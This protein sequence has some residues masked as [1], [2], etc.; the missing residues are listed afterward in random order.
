MLRTTKA[1]MTTMMRNNKCLHKQ[2]RLR[3]NSISKNRSDEPNSNLS[4][5]NKCTILQLKKRIKVFNTKKLCRSR[6]HQKWRNREKL[7]KTT[8]QLQGIHNE[9]T[10]HLLRKHVQ[11][12][13]K[14]LNA[15]T[16]IC[17]SW[18][19][20]ENSSVIIQSSLVQSTQE[21]TLS[22]WKFKNTNLQQKMDTSTCNM[23]KRSLKQWSRIKKGFKVGTIREWCLIPSS[24][25]NS[26][27]MWNLWWIQI[28]INTSK[29][30]RTMV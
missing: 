16:K 18:N 10:R 24:M 15:P 2:G 30:K 7:N 29:S 17:Q 13:K 14:A 27:L 3:I 20:L 8:S 19:Y 26:K 5:I 21:K 23:T 25:T 9:A 1:N 12:E 22:L 11:L 28:S 6:L 4:K